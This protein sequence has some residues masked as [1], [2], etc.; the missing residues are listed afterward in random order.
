MAVMRKVIG[1]DYD[2]V[3]P[4]LAKFRN[5]HLDEESFRRLF[6]DHAGSGEGYHGFLV[7]DGDQVAGY[8]GCIF[9]RR[10]IRGHVHSIC[11]ITSWIVDEKFRGHGHGL[12]L[13]QQVLGLE[14]TTITALT[15]STASS[16]VCRDKF[17]MT[18]FDASQ[19]IILPAPTFGGGAW[20]C[21]ILSGAKN[22]E[23]ALD[24]DG[25]RIVHDHPFPHV[26]H[27]LIRTDGGDCHVVVNRSRKRIRNW[28]HLPFA[29]VHHISNVGVFLRTLGRLRLEV[30]LRLGVFGLIVEDRY[31]A[32]A[33][34]PCSILR[35]EQRVAFM[36]S[37]MLGPSDIDGLYSELV[38]LNF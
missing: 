32:G 37:S 1:A 2:R 27:F 31:L 13:F 38:F 16:E 24:E 3:L 29:R 18:E 12:A 22:I 10:R 36:K 15:P 5:P 17:G 6:V 20:R 4:L 30:A 9:S 34:V 21:R 19:R 7:E 23:Q 28:L 8:I 14:G 11:N 26:H 35:R 25:R 33:R